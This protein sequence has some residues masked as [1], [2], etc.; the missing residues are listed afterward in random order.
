[1][2]PLQRQEP[3]GSRSFLFNLRRFLDRALIVGAVAAM[4][5]GAF[6]PVFGYP[7]GRP[8]Q[9][10]AVVAA[11]TAVVGTAF[12][13]RGSQGAF[14]FLWAAFG[15]SCAIGTIGVFSVGLI[16]LAAAVFILFAIFATPNNSPIELRYDWRYIVAFY[17]GYLLFFLSFAY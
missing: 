14:T 5:Y 11:V 8:V 9:V 12:V 15:M 6:W 3:D 16:Y 17:V 4:F 1:M 7:V 10:L 13:P 2:Q